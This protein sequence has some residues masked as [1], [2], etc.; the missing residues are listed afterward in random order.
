MFNIC[1]LYTTSIVLMLVS[2]HCSYSWFSKW[3]PSNIFNFKNFANL[4]K[5]QIITYCYID[6]QNLVKIG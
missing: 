1:C 2:V 3:R 5:S 6:V 4:S